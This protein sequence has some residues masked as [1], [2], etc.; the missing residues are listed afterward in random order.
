MS[1]CDVSATYV[2]FTMFANLSVCF[3]ADVV[4]ENTQEDKENMV[5]I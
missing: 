1:L 3:A 5:N 2:H 4:M